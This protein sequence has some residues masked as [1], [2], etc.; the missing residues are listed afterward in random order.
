MS[1]SVRENNL[2]LKRSLFNS[3]RPLLVLIAGVFIVLAVGGCSSGNQATREIN[4]A[5][6]S[7]MPDYVQT[8]PSN[9]QEAYRFAAANPDILKQMPCYCGCGKMGHQ[10]NLACYVKTVNA[11]GSVAEFDSHAEG[12]TLCVD[13][14]RD[15]MRMW[16]AGEEL[17]TIRTY[18]DNQ[19]S[20]FGPPTKTGPVQSSSQ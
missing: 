10:S 15:V 6:L 19:Y 2:A 12:C 14:A 20:S 3:P 5:P 9:V 17:A 8:A 16:Q 7:Q 4:L 1:Q 11:D 13:I 18:I